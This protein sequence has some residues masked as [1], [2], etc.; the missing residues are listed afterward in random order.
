[1]LN[2]Y[3]NIDVNLIDTTFY[4]TMLTCSCFNHIEAKPVS[5]KENKQIFSMRIRPSVKAKLRYIADGEGLPMGVMIE[6]L[7]ENNYK[8]KAK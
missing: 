4:I 6:K 8:R 1:M 3:N 2:A 5:N 7:I